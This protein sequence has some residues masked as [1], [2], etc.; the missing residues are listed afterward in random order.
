MIVEV[1]ETTYRGFKFELVKG[2][3]WKIVLGDEAYLFP[4]FQAAKFAVDEFYR[5]VIP[6]NQGKKLKHI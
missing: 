5:D 6:K 1:T 3:G 4:H 2:N